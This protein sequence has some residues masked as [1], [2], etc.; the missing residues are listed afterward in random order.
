MLAAR[1]TPRPVPFSRLT[2]AAQLEVL[3]RPPDES[4]ALCAPLN[5]FLR[6][7]RDRAA[8]GA[9]RVTPWPR[10]AARWLSGRAY[11]QR[12]ARLLDA[13]FGERPNRSAGRDAQQEFMIERLSSSNLY[14]L[15][16]SAGT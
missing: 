8:R 4:W 1:H 10:A 7:W 12:L 16:W 9:L 6:R 5:P 3:A 15:L 14:P 11:A 13:G 2:L